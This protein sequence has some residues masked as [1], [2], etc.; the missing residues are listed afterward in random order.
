MKSFLA[1]LALF[2]LGVFLITQNTVVRTGFNLGFFTGGYNPPT[3]VLLIPI[4]IGIV[5]LF[6]MDKQI[7]GWI[8]IF[9][10]VCI[11]LIGILMGLEIQFKQTSLFITILMYG[12]AAAGAGLMIKGVIQ[13][14]KKPQNTNEADT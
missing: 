11:I 5:M 9:I 13:S 4:L 3:G 10:G 12:C 8:V 6:L 14:N 7:W 1:G 2:V